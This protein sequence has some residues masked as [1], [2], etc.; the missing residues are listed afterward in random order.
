MLQIKSTPLHKF[1]IFIE[2]AEKIDPEW[3]LGQ[4]DDKMNSIQKEIEAEVD[5]KKAIIKLY[6]YFSEPFEKLT[7][8]NFVFRLGYGFD[9]KTCQKILLKKYPKITTK[10]KVAIIL[11]ELIELGN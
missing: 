10:T 9:G 5:G 6:D 2:L 3:L 11:Y 4:F 8:L 1:S 7:L